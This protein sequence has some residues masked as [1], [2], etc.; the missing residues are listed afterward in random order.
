MT[1]GAAGLAAGQPQK[2]LRK[3]VIDSQQALGSV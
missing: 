2:I 1:G 3:T